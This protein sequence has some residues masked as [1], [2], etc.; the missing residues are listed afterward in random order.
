MGVGRCQT[1]LVGE[2]SQERWSGHSKS[3]HKGSG[4]DENSGHSRVFLLP[5]VGEEGSLDDV[6][7]LVTTT[8]R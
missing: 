1:P 4:S 3:I 2:W 7:V 8:L 6:C 5:L